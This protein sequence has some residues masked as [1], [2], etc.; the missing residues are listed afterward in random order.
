MLDADWAHLYS[1]LVADLAFNF[2]IKKIKKIYNKFFQFVNFNIQS[3]NSPWLTNGILKSIRHKK[4]LVL[5]SNNDIDFETKLKKY[6][7]QLINIIRAAKFDYHQQIL[8]QLKNNTRK[9]WAH[10]TKVITNTNST[11]IPIA[12]DIL[13]N[14]FT[15]VYKQA[16]KFQ[17]DQH[18]TIPDSN[19]VKN[20]LFLS[21]II[22]NEMIDV[23]ASIFN[24]R[25]LGNDGLLSEIFI[26]NATLICQ[27]LIHIFN[28]SFTQG[29]FP[30]LLK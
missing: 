14:F 18:H 17:V 24:S 15:S 2:F 12:A 23:F 6:K 5:K 20:S 13:D 28:L 10:L 25:T 27:Q 30:N 11:N 29:V 3:K 16:P 26:S 7:N 19:F 9:M 22:S 8:R 1:L 4:K 21:P